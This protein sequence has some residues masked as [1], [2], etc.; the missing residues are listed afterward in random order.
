MIIDEGHRMKNHHCKLTCILNTYY[1]APRRLLLTGTPL[2]NKLPELW[3]LLNFLLPSIFKSVNTFEQWFNAPFAMTCEK[4]ELNAEESM[5]II[6]R[7]HKVLRPFLLRRL[8]KEVESQLPDKV[9]YVIK[10]DMSGLQKVVYHHMAKKGIMLTEGND[11]SKGGKGGAKALM[12]TIMQLRKLCN[13]PFM[14]Q[15][16]EEAYA[17]HIGTPIPDGGPMISGPDLYRVSGKFEL[18]DRM[19]PKLKAFGHRVLVFCQMTSLM[20]ILEDY[21][22]FKDFKYLRL[23]GATRGDDR[24]SLLEKFNRPNSEY[25]IFLLST[26]AGGLGLNL[27]T[28]DTVII[29]DSD[30][31]P[32]QDMQVNTA[33]V[34]RRLSLNLR[35]VVF[36]GCWLILEGYKCC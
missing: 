35:R 8:K 7:L 4:V 17:S 36:P 20:T 14:F 19:L 21:L 1:N 15:H 24:G 3:A 6:R 32:H 9:E 33:H 29:F 10:C 23:D 22:Q 11:K 25:F 5:L 13:H 34:L 30:W 31:N 27:Q 16:L 26:R 12:N 2:Q 28:A 18:L